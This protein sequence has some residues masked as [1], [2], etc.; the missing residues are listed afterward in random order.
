MMLPFV[1]LLLLADDPEALATKALEA[2]KQQRTDEAERLWKQALTL[3]PNLFPAAF[4]LGYLHYS[5][6]DCAAAEPFL[7]KAAAI[8]PKDFNA[9]Y[10]AGVC[11]SQLGRRMR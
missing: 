6:K 7:S 5:R 4:N 9:N 11:L 1:L 2:A 10:L 8:N 3:D